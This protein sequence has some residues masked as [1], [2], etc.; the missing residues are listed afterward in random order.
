[1]ELNC[2]ICNKK[3][4]EVDKASDDYTSKLPESWEIWKFGGRERLYEFPMELEVIEKLTLPKLISKYPVEHQKV[5]ILVSKVRKIEQEL[6]KPIRE[7]QEEVL[8][9]FFYKK[10]KMM[11]HFIYNMGGSSTWNI[12]ET[13]SSELETQIKPYKTDEIELNRIMNKFEEVGFEELFKGEWIKKV[14]SSEEEEEEGRKEQGKFRDEFFKN[15]EKELNNKILRERERAK[16]T[17]TP[18]IPITPLE[19]SVVV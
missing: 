10:G 17:R 2:N 7:K 3:F 5:K 8:W 18:K 15:K 1:M 6:M 19:L 16:M 14:K 11:P 12:C 13:C 4:K 9:K